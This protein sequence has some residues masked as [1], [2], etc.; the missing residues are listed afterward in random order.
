MD[1]PT[2][3][4]TC[5]LDGCERP[6]YGRGFCQY[7][8]G[9]KRA[10]GE[11]VPLPPKPKVCTFPDCG[12]KAVSFGLCT[13]HRRQRDD[14]QP[15]RPVRRRTPPVDRFW[16]HVDKSGD[17][18]PWT[19]RIDGTGYGK[20]AWFG[21]ARLAHRVAYEV[22]RGPIPAGMHIDHICRNRRC[23]NPDHLRLATNKQNAENLS[24][25]KNNTSGYRGVYWD[26]SRQRWSCAVTHN[27]R[28]INLGRYD[29]PE[30]AHAVVSEW[31][32]EN[33]THSIEN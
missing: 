10:D 8:Y 18:W 33:F 19:G 27:R 28:T 13:S 24:I 29:T 25:Q 15:L 5:T 4:K 7:H 16:S 11:L 26:R 23:V 32:R 3:P 20:V 6:F 14:G 2:Y 12:D 21:K 17:C 22:T 9:R 1:K 30:E 31:R